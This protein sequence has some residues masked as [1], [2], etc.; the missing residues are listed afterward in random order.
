MY[1]TMVV[2]AARLCTYERL[3][4][5][6]LGWMDLDIDAV[7]HRLISVKRL[8]PSLLARDAPPDPRPLSI[9]DSK[10]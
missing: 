7:L 6:S 8:L 5:V 4:S 9:D 1:Y 3:I 10:Q 2:I